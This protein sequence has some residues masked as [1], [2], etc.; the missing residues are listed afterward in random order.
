MRHRMKLEIINIGHSVDK[1]RHEL[2]FMTIDWLKIY[3]SYSDIRN[4]NLLMT[5]LING[6]AP[7]NVKYI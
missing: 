6:N 2:V 1:V 4:K 7:E 3:Y 5:N